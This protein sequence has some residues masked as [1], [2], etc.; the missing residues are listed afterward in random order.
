MSHKYNRIRID[1]ELKHLRDYR[2]CVV[3]VAKYNLYNLRDI[4][5]II[6]NITHRMY[7]AY[8]P[9]AYIGVRIAYS[10]I[11]VAFTSRVCL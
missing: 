6:C 11:S 9:K 3:N 1:Y 8:L 5:Y 4:T 2:Y 7:I 10:S